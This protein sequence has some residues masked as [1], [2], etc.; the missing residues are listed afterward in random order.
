MFSVVPHRHSNAAAARAAAV[1]KLCRASRCLAG[2]LYPVRSW[3]EEC[4]SA[5]AGP[6]QSSTSLH[7]HNEPR[8]GPQ[9]APA[10]ARTLVRASLPPSVK[11][12]CCC[13][14]ACCRFSPTCLLPACLLAPSR[15]RC[16]LAQL[17]TAG[18]P[19]KRRPAPVSRVRSPPAP[20]LLAPSPSPPSHP[21]PRHTISHARLAARRRPA[22]PPLC[23][24]TARREAAAA[25]LSRH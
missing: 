1:P 13:L 23:A 25:A 18:A 16:L 20:P 15:R 6:V 3:L 24:C 14:P 21:A 19:G 11:G 9:L 22:S 10:L 7:L 5:C 2:A 17:H 8:S 12:L 4:V